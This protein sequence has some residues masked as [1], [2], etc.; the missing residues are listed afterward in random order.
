M[1]TKVTSKKGVLQVK[2][3]FTPGLSTSPSMVHTSTA[4]R[5]LHHININLKDDSEILH[6]STRG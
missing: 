2:A 1:S 5:L 6:I 4:T 3:C